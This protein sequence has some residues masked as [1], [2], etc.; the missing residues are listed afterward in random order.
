MSNVSRTN[1]HC[2]D[3]CCT[4]GNILCI[5][6]H[7]THINRCHPK[8]TVFFNSQTNQS[9]QSTRRAVLTFCARLRLTRL[10]NYPKLSICAGSQLVWL[11]NDHNFFFR[12]LTPHIF[13]RNQCSFIIKTTFLWRVEDHTTRTCSDLE[14]WFVH[15]PPSHP[16]CTTEI[17]LVR[18]ISSLFGDRKS[19]V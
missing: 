2:T 19:V 3:A 6:R 1:K 15:I 4:F 16:K 5:P 8:T 18:Q 7:I 12:D 10:G 11:K 9:V 13:T 17:C 14:T